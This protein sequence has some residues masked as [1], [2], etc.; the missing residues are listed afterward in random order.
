MG[1]GGPPTDRALR[2]ARRRRIPRPRAGGRRRR[3][4][5]VR[6]RRHHLRIELGQPRRAALPGHRC[7]LLDRPGSGLSDP[8]PRPAR[9]A[10]APGRTR[11]PSCPRCSTPSTSRPPTS[12]APRSAATSRCGPL[13]PTRSGSVAS[14]PWPF[15]SV[16]RSRPCPCRC[17]SP[18]PR[19]RAGD[20]VAAATPAG[21]GVDAAAGRAPPRDRQRAHGRRGHRLVPQPPTGHADDAQRGDLGRRVGHPP[22]PRRRPRDAP[23]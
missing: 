11:T 14:S 21:G 8:L 17:G 22:D 19:A 3:A 2:G 7:L 15:R 6:A 23:R 20:G 4:R 10:A 12:S 13:P 18:G 1:L 16:R 9:D 5:P